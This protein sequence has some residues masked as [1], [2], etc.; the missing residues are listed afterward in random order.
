MREKHLKVGNEALPVAVQRSMAEADEP[1]VVE[2][3]VVEVEEGAPSA[4]TEPA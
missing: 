3:E 1:D 4:E 2:A